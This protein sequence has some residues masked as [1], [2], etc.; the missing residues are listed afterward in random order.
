[1]K[2][3]FFK[4]LIVSFLMISY[5]D[6]YSQCSGCNVTITAPNSGTYNLT[7][8]QTV[9]IVGTGAFT[10]TLNNF[11]G[12]TL[13]I[14]TGVTYNPLSTPNYNGN[15]TII[16]NGTFQNVNN[17]NFNTGT[18]FTNASTGTV[19]FTGINIGGAFVNNG[20]L[21]ANS[22][23]A[24]SSITLGGTT[25]IS[26]SL[27]NNATLT[28]TGSLVAGTITNN[29][30]IVGGTGTNCN[31]I[32][33]TGSFSNSG[34][35]GLS[36][37]YLYVGNTGGLI[38]SPA[39]T[40]S[41]TAPPSQPTALVLNNTGSTIN[42]SFTQ[43]TSSGYVILRAIAASVPATTNPTNMAS[44][45]VGQTLGA[46]TVAAINT[47]QTTT[48]FAD[49]VGATCTNVYYRIYAF[50]SGGSCR[51]YNTS[52]ALT[53]T[54][55]FTPTITGNTPASRCATGTVTLGA[56]TSAG[57][58]NWYTAATGGSSIGTGT[59]F[60]TPSISSTTTYYVD[61]TN[62]GCTNT[63]RTGVVATINPNLP[64]SVSIS[65]SAASIC[66]GTSVTFTATPTNGG[67]TPTYQWKVNGTNVSGQTAST[68][69]TTTLA[70]N[71]V[72][73]VVMTSNATPCLT[74]SPATSNSITITVS[75]Y[76]GNFGNALK[77]DGTNDYVVTPN[78]ASSM[79][80]NDVT[81]EL[82][83]KANGAGVIVTELGQSAIN[84]GWHDSH[85]EILSTGEVRVRVWFL[86]SISLGFVSFGTWNHAVVRYNSSN[87]TLDG[88]L[89]GV[90][91]TSTSVGART[92]STSSG[93]GY[94]YAFGATDSTNMGS[95]AYFNGTIDEVRI[96][97]TA[98][99]NTQIQTYMNTELSGSE[100]GLVTYYNFNQGIANG[101][102][103]GLTTLYDKTSNA[104]NGTLNNFALTGTASN[105][106]GGNSFSIAPITG[107][108]TINCIGYTSQLNNVTLGGVWSSSNTA[109]ATVNSN[110]LVTSLSSGTTTI[111]YTLTSGASCSSSVNTTLT[112]GT[113]TIPTITSTT[114][115]SR[116]E[117]GTVTLG[118]TASSGTINWY[119][120]ATGG[121]SLGTGNSF[122]TPSLSSTTTYYVDANN[123]C[124]TTSRTA[125]VATVSTT[126]S[127]TSTTPGTRT[128]AGSVTLGATAS[129]GSVNWYTTSTGGT[130]IA[131]GTS[132]TTPIIS[133]TTTYYVE[134]VNGGCTSTPRI[135]VVA[136]IKYPE[137]DVQGN[138]I[139]IVNNDITPSTT[140]W[141]D[142]GTN[143]TRTF[144]IYNTGNASL[145][146]GSVAI[147][148]ANAGDFT[149]TSAPNSTIAIGSSTTFTIT[150][151]PSAI[152][153][154]TATITFTNNDTDEDPYSFDIQATGTEQEI[155]VM[156]NAISIVDGD[157]TPSTTDWTDFSNIAGT[158][159]YTISNLGN[160]ELNIGAITISGANAS[161]FT[162]TS[163]PSAT[164]PA[165]GTTTFTVAFNPTAINTRT[166]TISIA[167]DD[168][169]EN[170]Y[171]FAIQGFGIIPEIDIQGNATSIP[172]SNVPAATTTNW[173]DFSTVTATRTF[174]IFNNGN[175]ALNIGAITF[176]G[177][178]ASE[179]T[180]TTPPSTSVAAFGTTTFTVT[181]APTAV[182]TRTAQIHIVN[183]DSN[184]NPY[185][186]NLQG[187]GVPR[188]IDLQGNGLSI[189][190]GDMVTSINDGTDFGPADIN[191][192][193]VTR[194]FTILN[195]GSIAMTISNPTITGANASE[196]SITAN[197]STLTIG[198]NSST[199]FQV[200]F[201]PTAVFTR[202]ATINIVNNDSDENPYTF[203]IQGTGL[204]DN[205][206]DGIDNSVDQDD[207][208]DGIVDN[209]ECGT[210]ISDPFV[211]GSFENT[212]PL[213]GPTNWGLIPVANVA[214]WQTTPENV[215]EV[216]SNNFLGVPAAAGNQFVELNANV[217]GT[218]YQ[219][220]CLNGAGGTI[221]WAI[222]HRGRAG[223]DQ[224]FVK[225]GT[226]L[227]TALAS[228]PIAT[229]V[230]GNT[231][232]GSYSGT[233]AIP[234]GQT[235]I[236]L[237]FQAG[238]TATGNASVGNLIDDV[239]IIINQNCIDSDA[240]GV[241][242][243][244]DVDDEN[245]G[246]PDIEE[247]GFK[248]YSGGKSTM[249][250][251]NS[252]TW[253]DTNANGV[254]DYI[255][256]MITAGTYIIPDT[257]GD[258]VKNYMDFDS[259]NDTAFDVDE[260]NLLNGDGD[261]NGDGKG[262][263]ADSDGDGLLNLYDNST[264]FGTTARA[265]AQDTDSN[266]IPDYLDLDSNDDGITD[267]QAGLYG[268]FDANND[269][270]IDGSG[271]ADG[272]GITDAFDTNDAV[273]G[274]PRDLNRK[275]Y[276]DFDGRNDYA[277]DTP[278]LGGLS[279]A[280]LMAW[281]DLSPTFSSTG[282]VVGQDK[283]QIRV[284]SARILQA[285][286]NGTPVT[287]GTALTRA[288]W[289]HVAATF[290]GGYL[291][292]YLNGK[293][294]GTPVA[295][296]G[297][298]AA[299]ATKLTLGRNPLSNI[300][301]FKGKIDEVRVFNTTL[302]ASQIERM[303]YQ[304]I[305]N[306]A[307][308]VQGA[309]V[310][311]DIGSLPFANLLRYYRMDAY[312]DD[313]V[314]NLTTTTIDTGTGMKLYNHKVINVQQAPMPFTTVRT[315]TFASAV[316]DATKDI[317]GTDVTTFDYSIIQVKHN[318]TETSNSTDLA[319][320]VDPGVTITM[321]N[322]TKLQNDWYL[323]LDGKIDLNGKSQLVQTINSDLDITSSGSIERDQ[324][325]SKNIYN[326]NYW[327]SPVGAINNTS[328][329]N[330]FTIAGVMKDGTTAT[331]QN[332]T[333]TSGLD[334]SPTS[335][336]TVSNYWIFKFQNLSNAY[337][338]WQSI[339]SGGTLNAAQG[340][341]MKGSGTS[342]SNQ[343]YTFVGKPN[344]GTITTTVAGGNLN[345]CGN[346][347]PSALDANAFISA[348]TSAITGTLYFWEHASNN[349]THNIQGYQ[350]GYSS[351]NLTGGTGPVAPADIN[352]L[353][354][355]AKTPGRF[356]PVSQGFFVVATPAG[357]TI[358]FDN[359]QRAFIKEDNV[360]SSTLFK[361]NT[362][363]V[364]SPNN[365]EQSN[366]NSEDS[367][368]KD[369]FKR[370]R[371]G[372]TS[373]DNYHR[374]I[375]LGFMENN[376]TDAID[377]GYDGLN[378]DNQPNDMYFINNTA[379]LNIQG[380]GYFDE[381][382]VFPIGIKN[383]MAGNVNIMIDNTEN[384][385]TNQGIYILDNSNG[386]YHNITSNPYTVQLPQGLTEG[387]FSLT[388]K[389][390]NALANNNFNL[391]D[392][393]KVA[394]VNTKN[395]LNIKNNVANTT[396]EKVT[397]FNMLGQSIVT[398]DVKNQN[399]QNIE[400]PI[401][402]LSSGTYIVKIKTDNGEITK[403]I[404][405]N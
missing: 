68:F 67:T 395:T 122:T 346:P 256:A 393:I 31:S 107:T 150:F 183:N 253:T 360:D 64:A 181:F 271:D 17:L 148:G 176:T 386:E 167:N 121:T 105:Y 307:S 193:T 318:I 279:N 250:R 384:M 341:T 350:G 356:I 26:S 285:T 298:I 24:N 39:T 146:I 155:D 334:G 245:D 119:A 292:L 137:I 35:I 361:T 358:T 398:F 244:L 281:I 76:P 95:G 204:L 34:T 49:N 249:D 235:N 30:T 339:G 355:S 388:F 248:A 382:K 71:D 128:G 396:V 45:S 192:V 151:S 283:F 139:S 106:V 156:G 51:V 262:D 222:K 29:N 69:T 362:S 254:N 10:G 335:P 110:G 348:N 123:G 46:W 326:Y 316:N 147:L 201:N 173:T 149:V 296:S 331:P 332:I 274:S 255:D 321:N 221:N 376:A 260:S 158:R 43:C 344:N 217:P 90:V 108:T 41:P 196:F 383:N 213:I 365:N 63:T 84:S 402:E 44:L 161:D 261:I 60:T 216:W 186:F 234:V 347:Y 319:M 401:K 231:A 397:L 282:I 120:A 303:V 381:N 113:G 308:Q 116:C 140:D 359:S 190:S 230:D 333:W 59:S 61:A 289:Y 73:S 42:G 219:S 400:L 301:Y 317:N 18:S 7:A 329:N 246:I 101:T 94:N 238:Y 177:T 5:L 208:N 77:L 291:T 349:A 56:T 330:P 143:L 367:Y 364:T 312:K 293:L 138:A 79:P 92:K 142:F 370:V 239:Q 257:D 144:T 345:L 275:L 405:F 189:A 135:A 259:D 313:I 267:I 242:D 114:P 162:V 184:E 187:T 306:T 385:D 199:T 352:G 82:W 270:K 99:T 1:M 13:C 379:K 309:I 375:L 153:I 23:T 22:I 310:P 130:P 27:T 165:F 394:Y 237:T 215:I 378:I 276:L 315:G 392:G 265:Y 136:T 328:N 340:F 404:I 322:D 178:N 15:W 103:T 194:T 21:T 372:I 85:M 55:N 81:L 200:T 403:K 264:N 134:A 269:G 160:L 175:L 324:Q 272:D 227:A 241:A 4:L 37:Q 50:N 220:F 80:T 32:R 320:F 78:I 353:G 299:D 191:L 166:A 336:I 47:G 145:S 152:G 19:A 387:R 236:V 126:T 179:F 380:V 373:T 6:V 91:S 57:T 112:V 228:S 294:V 377:L 83:F 124:T 389:D 62:N 11:N 357:G 240:D 368:I 168:N 287:F 125:I 311:R 164:I 391:E 209:I 211:N 337:A 214:G 304:E 97:N 223:T 295:I 226:T 169:S 117:T 104:Y 325:G 14:G 98:R 118:A 52:S 343:N 115:S 89:N 38:I 3:L 197:P 252:T 363:I 399:Q 268:S 195:T 300:N 58:I 212:N 2:K 157:S 163:L 273:K 88:L 96:W 342:S 171:D 366:N 65:S 141:T 16:N 371:L 172:D 354:T 174:T 302:T 263:G 374:Q 54:Y 198:A 218:L 40:S 133:T 203:S 188:E 154:S 224:A 297:S 277:E 70:N 258:G 12:N 266:G 131:T 74:G 20:T 351:R 202:V 93:Y 185:D 369:T 207:D 53:G 87:S 280:T 28:I 180:V 286:V 36:G 72:V 243:L 182:G 284:T 170:P 109:V 9:C 225:F 390:N 127:I 327:S 232:W 305:Q 48:T 251:S 210:C 290:G 206:G 205:D 247:A 86:N 129:I 338:N 288:R 75:N 314:D 66:I 159:T 132:F 229:M 8:G 233:Y 100:S 111:T 33:S 278:I 102:N 25:T 323:K